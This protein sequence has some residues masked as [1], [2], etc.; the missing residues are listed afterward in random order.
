MVDQI[1]SDYQNFA[2]TSSPAHRLPTLNGAKALLDAVEKQKPI[3]TGLVDLDAAL[4]AHYGLVEA[5]GGIIRGCVTEIYGP[6][7][8][9]KT[10]F[11]MQIVANALQKSSDAKIAWID[12]AS[13]IHT[14]RLKQIIQFHA[15]T[16]APDNIHGFDLTEKEDETTVK[17]YGRINYLYI[18]SFPHLLAMLL[19]PDDDFLE[20][21]TSLLVIDDFS[22]IVLSGLPQI[23]RSTST[24]STSSGPISREEIILRSVAARRSA[25]MSSVSSGLSSLAAA[26]NIAVIVLN[27]TSSYRKAGAKNSILRS[28]LN[29]Q[30]WNENI[31]TRIVLYRDFWPKVDGQNLRREERRKRRKRERWPLRIACL[32][33]SGGRE[34]RAEGVKFVILENHLH[35][36]DPPK[37][38]VTANIVTRSSPALLADEN[39]EALG[40]LGLQENEA[41]DQ[42]LNMLRDMPSSSAVPNKRKIEE[43][44]DSEDEDEI[45]VGTSPPTRV[46]EPQVYSG[47]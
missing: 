44:A 36:V 15:E 20:E 17:Y 27:K 1:E 2:Q 37:R 47:I 12:T 9:G 5:D 28:A 41:P 6:P 21:G 42:R 45:G 29:V 18:S 23:D 22:N 3:P 35:A 43:V 38:L 7:G 14:E 46:M 26:R 33:K 40:N 16:K 11:A 24:N 32:E 10:R 30:Q 19:A 31:A 25:L 34:V 39:E 4:S 8:S 13:Q